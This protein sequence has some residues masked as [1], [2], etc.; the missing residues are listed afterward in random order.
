VNARGSRLLVWLLL[1]SVLLAACGDVQVHVQ[2]TTTAT[3]PVPTG[4]DISDTEGELAIVGVDFDPPLDYLESIRQQGIML[5]VAVEN[6]GE[7][8]REGVRIYARL[9][10]DRDER[11]A[12]K[13]MGILPTLPPHQIVVYRFPRL[14]NIPARRAYTLEV[15]LLS[16]NGDKVLNKRR[17]TIDFGEGGE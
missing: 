8:P 3:T 6:R 4:A 2:G 15:R 7:R 14:Y 1:F 10:Y 5:L 11:H 16:P 9:Q 13:R 17:Y 12:L